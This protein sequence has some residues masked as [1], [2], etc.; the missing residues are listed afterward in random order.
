MGYRAKRL[1]VANVARY[2]RFDFK[3]KNKKMLVNG[4]RILKAWD[5]LNVGVI[6]ISSTK[7]LVIIL[8]IAKYRTYNI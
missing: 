5:I 8:D 7:G 6:Y 2:G 4:A 1:L 3:L